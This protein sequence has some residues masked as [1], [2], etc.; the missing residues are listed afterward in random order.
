GHAGGWCAHRDRSRH[1]CGARATGTVG[2]VV[3]SPPTLAES[4]KLLCE[5]RALLVRAGEEDLRDA[6]DALQSAAEAWGLS[7]EIGAD[8]V[9][10]LMAAAFAKKND[11]ETPDGFDE[12]AFSRNI[13]AR[14]AKLNASKSNGHDAGKAFAKAE[15]STWK[16]FTG[17]AA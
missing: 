15:R 12:E 5:S 1:R 4:F 10:A 8:A 17:A 16:F 14:A 2:A 6:V 11:A 9:Q 3:M 7:R 13:E